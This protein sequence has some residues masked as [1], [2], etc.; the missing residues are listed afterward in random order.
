MT[1]PSSTEQDTPTVGGAIAR[2]NAQ[3]GLFL[4]AEH[5]TLMQDYSEDLAKALGTACGP[6]VVHGFP[7]TL[8]KDKV[9]VG[10]GLAVDPSGTVLE[11]KKTDAKV[12]FPKEPLPADGFYVVQL[13]EGKWFYG[14]D[15]VY[16][17]PCDDTCS[18]ATALHPNEGRGITVVLTPATLSGF[19]GQASDKRRNWLASHYFERERGYVKP[20]LQQ[21]APGRVVSP[22][23]SLA[24]STGLD[25]PATSG[26][27]IAVLFTVN[28]RWQVDTW[29]ARRDLSGSTALRGWQWRLAGRPWDV[30]LAQ[31]LQFQD[32]LSTRSAAQVTS[33]DQVVQ[34]L[35]AARADVT[36]G[37][38]AS[39]VDL[40][41]SAIGAL[42]GAQ[43]PAAQAVS[44]VERGFQ[45][46]PPAG[47]LPVDP[48]GNV[49][50]QVTAL[51]PATVPLTFYTCRF[52]Y[53]PQ[54]LESAQHSDR[55]PLD[56]SEAG[57]GVD[58]FIPS[59]Q[60]DWVVFAR[61]NEP[62][63]LGGGTAIGARA[64]TRAPKAAARRGD[65][66]V[67]RRA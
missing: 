44:L 31:V 14:T 40:L 60:P 67:T 13:L 45:D 34:W 57:L 33:L 24:W 36:G 6:G 3:D 61:N 55:I 58:V 66:G 54:V 39:S 19:D 29:T 51:F 27:P 10:P 28:G 1:T 35:D 30:F 62:V 20:W 64:T 46:L 18:G 5:L 49:A 53:T 9:V 23:Q 25:A 12:S 16:G 56:G 21:P 15:S 63:P 50:E 65:A 42:S 17:N 7:V 4:R 43:A 26:V 8:A 22:L 38:S 47:F 2:L 59:G 48:K 32:Q 11:S 52:D 37:A 41:N